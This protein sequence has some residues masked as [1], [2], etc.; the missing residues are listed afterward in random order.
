CE[1]LFEDRGRLKIGGIGLV[2]LCLRAGE[3]E[4]VEDLRLVIIGIAGSK[5]LVRLR[6]R[7]LPGGLGAVGPVL[8]VGGDGLDVVALALGRGADLP[9]LFDRLLRQWNALGRR[10]LSGERISHE[11]GRE[12]PPRDG[13]RGILLH[14]GG[15]GVAPRRAIAHEGSCSTTSRKVFSAAVYQNECSIATPRSNW[16]C[17]LG[18]QDV[19][20]LTLPSCS[21]LCAGTPTAS[22]AINTN[23]ALKDFMI[24]SLIH[25]PSRRDSPLRE[26][27]LGARVRPSKSNRGGP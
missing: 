3:I 26:V 7:H 12:A 25:H 24:P 5:P 1:L 13:A 19:G 16:A 23:V 6:A 9:R 27:R 22:A 10:A 21:A 15:E 18:S 14:D 11:D 4:R 20:K 8:V 17:T 2:G